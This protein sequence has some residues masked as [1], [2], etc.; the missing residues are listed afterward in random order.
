MSPEL[1]AQFEAFIEALPC[2]KMVYPASLPDKLKYIFWRLYTPYHP[3]W[4]DLL[5][6]W[7]VIHHAGRQKFVLG[8]LAPGESIKSL[9]NFLIS[10]G[11]GNNFIAWKEDGEVIGLR[12]VDNFTFQYHIRIFK[13]G[14]VRGHYE[15][16]PEC[17]PVWH[18]KAIGLKDRRSEFLTLLGD[19]I[20]PSPN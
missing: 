17:H 5:L 19:K 1:V 14:E 12:F 2:S 9:T 3:F 11:Y 7:G 20:I 4:R 13:D 16:T 8:R 10:R 6:S 15:Y 18:F